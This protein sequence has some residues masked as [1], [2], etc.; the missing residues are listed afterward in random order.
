MKIYV[1]FYTYDCVNVCLCKILRDIFA[2]HSAKCHH[3]CA[4][5][6]FVFKYMLRKGLISNILEYE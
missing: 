3:V 1:S 5:F 6:I 2:V 4:V